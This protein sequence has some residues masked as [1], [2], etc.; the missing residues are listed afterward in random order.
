MSQGIRFTSSALENLTLLN[1]R[2]LNSDCF[3]LASFNFSG[4]SKFSQI[5]TLRRRQNNFLCNF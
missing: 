2:K 4:F 5:G 1:L 3:I